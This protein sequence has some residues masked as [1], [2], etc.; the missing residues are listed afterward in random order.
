MR[1]NKQGLY[2]QSVPSS[3]IVAVPGAWFIE[4]VPAGDSALVF[5]DNRA[6]GSLFKL[7]DKAMKL[8]A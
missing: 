7:A 4:V 3:V 5:H 2:P 6:T 8:L 1:P